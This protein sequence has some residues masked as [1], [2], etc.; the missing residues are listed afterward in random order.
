M[1]VR[2]GVEKSAVAPAARHDR[3]R[4]EEAKHP[5]LLIHAVA[6]LAVMATL[7]GRALAPAL[8]GSVAGISR[9]IRAFD[10]L[11]NL[12]TQLFAFAGIS[13]ALILSRVILQGL[14]K[15]LVFKLLL[16]PA[17]L[18]IGF[19][20]MVK[21]RVAQA[22]PNGSMT[23]AMTSSGLA[24]A[25]SPALLKNEATRAMGLAV[26]LG[27]IGGGLHAAGRYLAYK[28]S[29]GSLPT[30][31]AVA[32]ACETVAF[33][34]HLGVVVL[35]ILWLRSR[36]WSFALK[37]FAIT[38]LAVVL[39]L[40]AQR[41]SL[42]HAA[43]WEVLASRM[44]GRLLTDPMPFAP[45]W[46]TGIIGVMTIALSAWLI[47]R[48]RPSLTALVVCFCLLSGRSTDVPLL[49]LALA[50]GTIVARLPSSQASLPPHPKSPPASAAKE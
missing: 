29:L 42:Y 20:V 3:D 10:L 49:A 31:F 6:A 27:G 24:L 7:V 46:V 9:I 41:G 14:K 2:S 13:C 1:L 16:L 25:A 23:L 4:R 47:A 43:V 40:G 34:L 28:A 19:L 21:M 30:E 37:L 12:L 45:E 15:D 11:G 32:R 44:L 5:T 22:D 33:V 8:P 50:L 39:A 35:A 18:L 36:G 17:T 38:A 48:L 26:T